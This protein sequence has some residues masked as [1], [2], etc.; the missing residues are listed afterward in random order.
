VS[1]FRHFTLLSLF[2]V[3]CSSPGGPSID[4]LDDRVVAVGDPILLEVHASSPDGRELDYSFTSSNP[5]LGDR[6]TLLRRPDGSGVFRWQPTALDIGSW[7]FD[8][9]AEDA[10]GG[11]AT[12]SIAIEVRS[13]IGDFPNERQRNAEKHVPD[14][15]RH[16]GVLL[17]CERLKLLR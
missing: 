16:D 9:T 3:G 2:A 1:V 15:A 14:H 11:T 12:E 4:P 10:D 17:L 5:R 6:A 8:F 7:T 13:A